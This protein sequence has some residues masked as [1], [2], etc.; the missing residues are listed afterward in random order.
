[1]KSYE[2][3]AAAALAAI[4]AALQLVH[5]GVATQW[6]MWIDL[7]AVSWIVAYFIYGPRTALAVSVVGALLITLMA[8]S[9]WLGAIMKWT[10]TVPIFLTLFV[11]QKTLRIKPKNL[12]KPVYLVM[13]VAA[14]L[15]IRSLLMIPMN[16]YFAI[17]IWVPDWSLSDAM[18]FVPWWAIAGVNTVQGVLEAA[19]AWI[20]VFRFRLDR[21]SE[22]S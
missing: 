17:P 13:A 16:Y 9:T 1:M 8:P 5:V 19:L 11:V 15:V 2:I 22:W 21:F 14:A 3:T 12:R 7:V 10:A 18:T 4:S 6:G 20:L